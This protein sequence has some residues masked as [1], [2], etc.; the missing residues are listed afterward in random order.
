M[1]MLRKLTKIT[2]TPTDNIMAFAEILLETFAAIGDAKALPITS[3]ATA[4]QCLPFSIVM[5][6]SELIKAMKN[7]VIFTVPK[8]NR[9]LLPPAIKLES[10]ME[11]H[12]PPPTAS[13]KPPKAPSNEIFL[14]FPPSCLPLAFGFNAFDSITPPK[15][16]VY[17]ETNGFV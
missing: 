2:I 15:I 12:P 13:I 11:P 1:I 6:V 16:K 4:S 10:T 8:E 7:L 14:I 9:G 5:N 3:P 17:S